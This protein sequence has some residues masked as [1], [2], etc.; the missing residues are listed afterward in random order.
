MSIRE[1]D[2]QLIR[3]ALTKTP[4]SAR[5]LCDSTG[6][7]LV[8]VH[9]SLSRLNALIMVGK[10]PARWR[11]PETGHV[12]TLAAKGADNLVSIDVRHYSDVPGQWNLSAGIVGMTLA[13][14]RIEPTDDPRQLVKDFTTAARTLMSVAYALK[15]VEK[16]P[17]WFTLLG[18]SL[19]PDQVS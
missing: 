9:A 12:L 4:Q 11:L 1:A 13:E 7:S 8:E 18:G 19:D 14:L 17:D 15:N 16:N 6:L 10:S 2:D 3:E 5:Q